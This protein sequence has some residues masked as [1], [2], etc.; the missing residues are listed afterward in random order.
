MSVNIP[1]AILS[2]IFIQIGQLFY[3]VSQ[4]NKNIYIFFCDS[5]VRIRMLNGDKKSLLLVY[6]SKIA[7]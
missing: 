2:E 7:A 1:S 3:E 6:Y 5:V 4:E